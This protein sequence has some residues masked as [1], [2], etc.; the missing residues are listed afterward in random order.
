MK[1]LTMLIL[2]STCVLTPTSARAD[3][4]GWWDWIWKWDPKFFIAGSVDYHLLCLD[5]SGRRI[6]GCEENFRNI[7]KIFG[8]TDEIE[9]R[10]YVSPSTETAGPGLDFSAIKH[11]FDFRFGA[12][13]N[14]GDRYKSPP[15]P[16]IDGLIWFL[17]PMLM[18]HYHVNDTYAIGG[19]AGFLHVRGDRFEA[20]NRAIYTPV[21]FILYPVPGKR[22][23][24]VREELNFIP[25]GFN[26]S[27]F[28]D[29]SVLFSTKH[30]WCVSLSVGFDLR[31]IGRNR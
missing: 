6:H 25:A 23:I 27:D 31:R 15:D 13:K 8:R 28:G 24:A 12:G 17:R 11:E 4:G 9:H 20:F 29:D 2:A 1:K 26:G 7:P 16:H 19:G 5:G 3:D 10:F 18:Y 30:E 21:S 22:A 14:S